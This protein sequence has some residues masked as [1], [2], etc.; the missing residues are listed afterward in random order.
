[1]VL[2][3]T[4]SIIP[5]A[6]SSLQIIGPYPGSEYEYE[7]REPNNEHIYDDYYEEDYHSNYHNADAERAAHAFVTTQK[8]TLF[9]PANEPTRKRNT[10]HLSALDHQG[11]QNNLWNNRH[12]NRP[13]GVVNTF[14]N[15]HRQSATD[16]GVYQPQV[17][18]NWETI[19][20]ILNL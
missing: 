20:G 3:H 19:L 1:M 5:I 15:I 13:P 14:N 10:Y 9:V 7:N 17:H 18:I 8:P 4:L 16:V 2:F 6:I 11:Q 12:H